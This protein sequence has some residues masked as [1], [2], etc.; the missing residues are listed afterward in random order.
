MQDWILYTPPLLRT[1]SG[2]NKAKYIEDKNTLCTVY[3]NI[4]ATFNCNVIGVCEL[5][6]GNL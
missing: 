2:S 6:C 1:T 5:L 4:D 3:T